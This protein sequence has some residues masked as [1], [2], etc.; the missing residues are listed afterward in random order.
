VKNTTI[1][2][3]FTLVY[4]ILLFF[5][6][7][8]VNR[9][10][11]KLIL[12]ALFIPALLSLLFLDLTITIIG[13]LLLQIGIQFFFDQHMI[14]SN[15][16]L[17]LPL[18]FGLTLLNKEKTLQINNSSVIYIILLNFLC[19]IFSTLIANN[20]IHSMYLLI[21][22]FQAFLVF[23]FFVWFL[24]SVKS[25]KTILKLYILGS[26]IPVLIGL[27]QIIS[28]LDVEEMNRIQGTFMSSNEFAPFLAFNFLL[29]IS[30]GLYERKILFKIGLFVLAI[31]NI[32][33]FFH[34][35]SR[36]AIIGLT[37][38]II[39]YIFLIKKSQS[40]RKVILIVIFILIIVFSGLTI[41]M[42]KYF[43]RFTEIGEGDFDFS[44]IERVGVWEAALKLFKS[45]PLVGVGVNN[46]QEEYPQ[47][48][49][50]YG[51]RL[52]SDKL[53]HA[54]N[55]LLNTLAEQGI[56][57]FIVLFITI[58]YIIKM[59]ISINKNSSSKYE[60][61]LSPFLSGYFVYFLLHNIFDCVWT[62]YYH[63][64]LQMQLALF[65]ALTVFI[66]KNLTIKDKTCSHFV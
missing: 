44:T 24:D 59:L 56:I 4:F 49:P 2:T 47:F 38:A 42:S 41:G 64:A 16:T 40:I 55:L 50:T 3:A 26:L 21:N 33:I 20:P 10:P 60:A 43:V 31:I 63:V 34:T 27:L 14:I 1:L 18:L 46:F 19:L 48:F 37:G 52:I 29:F 30:L 65:F 6:A 66:F 32:F 53:Y 45:S 25:L 22:Y 51:I 9:I 13:I 12:L 23:L 39:A 35:Y 54:H 36:G 5:V 8:F 58:L 61:V 28:V 62:A 7:I 11:D 15:F 57:G 17:S